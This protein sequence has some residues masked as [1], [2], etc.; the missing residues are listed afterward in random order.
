MPL[1]RPARRRPAMV[2]RRRLAAAGVVLL[3]APVVASCADDPHTN[4]VT[5]LTAGVTSREA[6]V[7]VLNALVVSAQPGSGTLVALL[8]NDA[9]EAQDIK[10]ESVEPAGETR[11]EAP[12]LRPVSIPAGQ[13]VNLTELARRGEGLRL[14]G[15]FVAGDVLELTLSFDNGEQVDLSVPVY[16]ACDEFAGLDAASSAAASASGTTPSPSGSESESGSESGSSSA[17][18][19]DFPAPTET[20]TGQAEES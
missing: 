15:D 7:G 5:N 18:T 16:T 10:L 3:T 8:V 19:C 14:A 20:A 2:V 17:Y 12:G 13:A 1:R 11:L 4:R 9:P 6:S